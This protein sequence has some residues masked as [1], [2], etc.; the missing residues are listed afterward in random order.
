MAFQLHE[1]DVALGREW[2]RRERLSF[3]SW[4][5]ERLHLKT[6][7]RRSELLEITDLLGIPQVITLRNH[8]SFGGEEAIMMTFWRLS[9]AT[10][11]H[12]VCEA[13]KIE[14]PLASRVFNY[15][16]R[17]INGFIE[18]RN[19]FKLPF[20]RLV[21]HGERFAEI[22]QSKTQGLLVDTIG[23]IDGTLKPICRPSSGQSTYYSGHKR[24]HGLRFQGMV[25]PDG[26][27]VHL[28]G[29][30]PGRRADG[31]VYHDSGILEELVQLE[32]IA[33]KRYRIA[34]D[35]GYPGSTY[36]FRETLAVEGD[37]RVEL[38]RQS[39]TSVEWAFGKVSNLFGLANFKRSG[40][41]QL[42]VPGHHYRIAIFLTNIH[43]C[44]NGSQ[45]GMWF[46]MD[47]PTV[48]EYL[49]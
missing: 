10:R 39:R 34:G 4:E 43:T 46:G 38:F 45:V 7:F 29:P 48:Q 28:F 5:E 30:A 3:Y 23:F 19:R 35:R 12:D 47:P 14:V 33:G 40:K 2:T 6:R 49:S 36:L 18:E 15:I 11:L 8:S 32:T 17:H 1:A 27:M 20:G 13:F 41:L 42:Q 9:Y 37:P 21:S 31:G 26:I 44:F 22:I 25:T 24:C 16:L